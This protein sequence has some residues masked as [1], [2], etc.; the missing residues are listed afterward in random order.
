ME[1]AAKS[2]IARTEP[3]QPK[4]MIFSLTLHRRQ[5]LFKIGDFSEFHGEQ[6]KLCQ[7]EHDDGSPY[8]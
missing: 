6:E 2:F 1:L 3:I 8:V 5:F 4:E 7:I